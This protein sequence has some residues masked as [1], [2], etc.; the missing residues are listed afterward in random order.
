MK[1]TLTLITATATVDQQQQLVPMQAAE[2][3]LFHSIG[4]GGIPKNFYRPLARTSRPIT[5]RLSCTRN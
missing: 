2:V 5:R 1:H 4:S 3:L